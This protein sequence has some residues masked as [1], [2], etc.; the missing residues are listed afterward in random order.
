MK[1]KFT[2]LLAM[3]FCFT[4]NANNILI[5]NISLEN[6]NAPNWVQVEFDLS[7]ENSWRL[8]A[9]PSNW[10]AAWVFIK[11]RVNSGEWLHAQLAQ[12]DFVASAGSTIAVTNDGVGAFIYRDSDGS[13]DLNLQNMRLRWDYGAID[14]NDIIDVQVFGVEMVYVPEGSFEVGGTSGDEVGKFYSL[15]STTPYNVSSENS[16]NVATSLGN[17]YYSTSV[18]GSRPGDQLGPIPAAFP[19]GFNAYYCMKYEMSQGQWVSFFNTLSPTQK[20]A[21]D[22]TGP[23]GKNSDTPLSRNTISWADGAGSATTT[24]PD[25]ALNYVNNDFLYAYLDWAGLRPMT[26]LEYEKACRGPIEPKAGEFA[27]GNANIAATDY[28]IINDSQPNELV[29]NPGVGTGNAN[30]SDTNGTPSGPKRVGILAASA[31]NKTR[32]ETGGSY[33]GIMEFTG[34]LYERC[35]TVGNPEGRAFTANHGNGI[36]TV[37]GRAN[38]ASWPTTNTGI[39][40]RGGSFFNSTAFIRVSDRYDAATVLAGANNRLGFR[41]VRSID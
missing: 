15:I 1:T 5:S 11:Y 3:S 16:I 18:V 36:L 12:T 28:T 8:S 6:L 13:G 22:I 19:K 2:F 40:Y 23:D 39:G 27:W 35:I 25:V 7:W 21:N 17:L 14:P 9:G 4:T 10:D 31:V 20:I 33:Y 26:E 37:D 41:G 34:N 30:Y 24:S 29:T 32:E 38:V